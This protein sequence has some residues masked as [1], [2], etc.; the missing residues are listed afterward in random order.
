M[1]VPAATSVLVIR[2]DTSC[3]IL[4]DGEA[5]G[6]VGADERLRLT[7]VPGDHEVTA[8]AAD[9]RRWERVVRT[10]AGEQ[11]I[12]AISL[13]A[14]GGGAAPSH[15]P[16]RG[17]LKPALTG[18]ALMLGVIALAVYVGMGRE[19]DRGMEPTGDSLLALDTLVPAGDTTIPP[20]VL[21]PARPIARQGRAAEAPAASS[22]AP[23]VARRVS[24]TGPVRVRVTAGDRPTVSW[25]PACGVRGLMVET[26]S[27]PGKSSGGTDAWLLWASDGDIFPPVEY[28]IVRPGVRQVIEPRQLEPGRLYQVGVY[29]GSLDDEPTIATLGFTTFRPD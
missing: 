21:I 8:V 15:Q 24:C 22:P 19:A 17:I 6:Q 7:V 10:P 2:A 9:G 26:A 29:N 25:S 27:E 11:T 23:P 16:S 4:L 20:T 3:R 18:A 1:S 12:V 5:A 14:A 13:G 28:G